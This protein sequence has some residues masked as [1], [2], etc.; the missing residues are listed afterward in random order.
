M[1]TSFYSQSLLGWTDRGHTYDYHNLIFDVEWE[2]M[3]RQKKD[4]SFV[5]NNRQREIISSIGQDPNQRKRRHVF[6][7]INHY[8]PDWMKKI[9]NMKKSES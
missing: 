9:K 6:S 8:P 5:T 4:E 2:G 3:P 1:L 7:T